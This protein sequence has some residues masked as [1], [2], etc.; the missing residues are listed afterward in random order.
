MKKA[1]FVL[2]AAGLAALSYLQFRPSRSRQYRT[3]RLFR[4]LRERCRQAECREVSL[5][6]H[7]LCHRRHQPLRT[8]RE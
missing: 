8:S 1:A 6:S 3:Q 2:L 7:R 5:T 4:Q